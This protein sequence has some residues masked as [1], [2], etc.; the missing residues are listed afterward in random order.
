MLKFPKIGKSLAGTI[1]AVT[2]GMTM[3]VTASPAF[4]TTPG[5]SPAGYSAA[6]AGASS[7]GAN[8]GAATASGTWYETPILS[9]VVVSGTLTVGSGTKCYVA[10][11]RVG[12]DIGYQDSD[13]GKQ[14]GV[15]SAPIQGSAKVSP[16]GWTTV[17][18]LICEVRGSQVVGCGSPAHLYPNSAFDRA[19][20]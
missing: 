14:C 7:W 8:Y 9:A 17:D 16:L 4:A 19:V 12:Q 18:A 1:A 3:A 2:T 15:G 6:Q 20:A 10:K 13:M 5:N 11:L